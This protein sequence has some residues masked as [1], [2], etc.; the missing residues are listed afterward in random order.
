MKILEDEGSI[1]VFATEREVHKK[2]EWFR[3][4]VMEIAAPPPPLRSPFEAILFD[5]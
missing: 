1:T 4:Q 5:G 3:F 2:N